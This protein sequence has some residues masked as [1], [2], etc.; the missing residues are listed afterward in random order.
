MNQKSRR[1]KRKVPV[2][3]T[4]FALMLFF[5]ALNYAAASEPYISG[6]ARN[7]SG[8]LLNEEPGYSILQNTFAL[9]FSHTGSAASFAA[10]SRFE[11]NMEEDA[12]VWIKQ[13]Y[14][15]LFF[16]NIEFRVGK[17]QIIWGKGDGVFI[18]DIVSPR[19]MRE[20]ILPDFDEIRKG[21]TALKIDYFAGSSRLELAWVPVFTAS[22]MP[23]DN[24]IWN[25]SSLPAGATLDSSGKDV[26]ARLENSE[27][28]FRYSALGSSVDWEVVAGWMWDDEPS[29][30]FDT[31]SKTAFPVHNRVAVAGGSFSYSPGNFILKG[32]AAFYAG[33]HFT[34]SVSLSEMTEGNY[35][36]TV[37]KNYLHYLAGID[38]TVFG[39]SFGSQFIQQA[40]LDYD[41]SIAGEQTETTLTFMGRKDFM[42]DKLNLEMFAYFGANE[43]D[44]L[45]RPKLSYDF[46]DNIGLVLGADIFLGNEGMFGRYDENDMV[47]TTVKYSF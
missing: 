46:S 37:K 23:E 22:V 8:I 9:D 19:D 5:A 14:V 39:V 40:V 31:A 26:K 42:R 38:F 15:D 1:K 29:V 30:E 13:L 2:L 32:D 34:P 3:K 7:R 12:D 18:T 45:L 28:F 33:K 11:A 25:V 20:F 4:F 16:E 44:W 21:V 47:Y 43:S 36:D 35:L 10:E 27:L 41:S 6:F 17:Q 24:S